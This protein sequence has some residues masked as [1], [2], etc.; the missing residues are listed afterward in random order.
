[1]HDQPE[2]NYGNYSAINIIIF[3]YFCTIDHSD[4]IFSGGKG[5]KKA[6]IWQQEK[7][8]KLVFN[9]IFT[10]VIFD[11]YRWYFE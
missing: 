5:S 1:M 2:L 7:E 10:E 8:K 11:E 3:S 4:A 9:G 6:T